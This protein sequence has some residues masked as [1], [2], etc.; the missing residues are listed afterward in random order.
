MYHVPC[1]INTTSRR[2]RKMRPTPQLPVLSRLIIVMI[3]PAVILPHIRNNDLFTWTQHES[4]ICC[5][6]ISFMLSALA[7]H[8]PSMISA[9]VNS[10]TRVWLLE[11]IV[12][13]SA[14]Q[15]AILHGVS[16]LGNILRMGSLLRMQRAAALQHYFSPRIVALYMALDMLCQTRTWADRNTTLAPCMMRNSL[17]FN[18]IFLAFCYGHDAVPGAADTSMLATH[19]VA[20][21]ITD[22]ARWVFHALDAL[23]LCR[24]ESTSKFASHAVVRQ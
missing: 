22:I 2:V 15:T 4:V 24:R 18:F 19:L 10:H 5:L 12:Y 6:P 1:T 23:A 13:Y 9:N 17:I 21:C 20:L 7:I 11:R 8:F 16:L 3:I 14:I